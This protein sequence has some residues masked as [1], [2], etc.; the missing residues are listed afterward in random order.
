[1]SSI[2]RIPGSPDVVTIPE[3]VKKPPPNPLLRREIGISTPV[4]SIKTTSS[5]TSLSQNTLANRVLFNDQRCFLTGDASAELQACHLVNA[6]RTNG[7]AVKINLKAQVEHLLTR[8]CFNGLKPFFLDSLAN[9]IALEVHWRNQLD[10]RGSFCI[11]V[12]VKQLED[13]I[14]K[15]TFLNV[16]WDTRVASD[17]T[18]PRN[19]DTTTSPFVVDV[20][21]ILILRPTLFLVDNKP[22]VINMNRALRT[23]SGSLPPTS[24][25]ASWVSHRAV[26]GSPFLVDG[27]RRAFSS[28]QFI[29]NRSTE[30]NI[31]MFSLILNAHYKL[32][33]I[34][35]ANANLPSEIIKYTALIRTLFT[36]MFYVPPHFR[37][38]PPVPLQVPPVPVDKSPSAEVTTRPTAEA[39]ST[40]NMQMD[41]DSSTDAPDALV[42][43]LDDLDYDSDSHSDSDSESEIIRR[44][45]AL[46][47]ACDPN[48]S[49][50]QK[51]SAIMYGLGMSSHPYKPMTPLI[52]QDI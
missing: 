36:L 49:T 48:V 33:S 41:I 24:S 21:V 14:T 15:L 7:K 11:V 50:G 25:D 13:M 30:D 40:S 37:Y 42:E 2:I 18:A 32:Q 12:P 52:E 46:R 17:P 23:R 20:C 19:L 27:D 31:S 35:Q 38:T 22:I 47:N 6:I 9:C 43:E 34:P 3:V 45:D 44:H 1:M 16:D 26:L 29:S 10:K 4:P 39:P 8:Q 28:L 5:L 51:L